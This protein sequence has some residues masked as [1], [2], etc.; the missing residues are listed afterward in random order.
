VTWAPTA[1]AVCRCQLNDDMQISLC[2]LDVTDEEP[3]ESS[4]RCVVCRGLAGAHLE[5]CDHC[6]RRI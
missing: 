3:D 6:A 4:E 1:H 2:G 5:R